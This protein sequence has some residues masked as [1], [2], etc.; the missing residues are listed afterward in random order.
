[1]AQ[2]SGMLYKACPGLDAQRCPRFFCAGQGTLLHGQPIYML[3]VM[4]LSNVIGRT[5]QRHAAQESGVLGP[6]S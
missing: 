3:G 4:Q 1:M 6:E 2:A 5:Q